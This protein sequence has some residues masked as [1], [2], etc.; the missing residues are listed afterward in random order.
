MILTGKCKKC[1]GYVKFDIDDMKREEVEKI[2]KNI[3]QFECTAG[4][5]VELMSPYDL[6]EFDWDNI[7]DGKAM[8]ED[9]FEAS[10][11]S[12]FDE[13]YSSSEFGNKYTVESFLYGKCLCHPKNG[14]E[15][16]LAVFDFTS[17]PKGNRYYFR[18]I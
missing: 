18:M 14:D 3:K 7:E 8:T 9:E 12:K 2:L 10:M 17:S 5:H 6:Y 15:D 4:N 16:D 11:K 13:V 1:G